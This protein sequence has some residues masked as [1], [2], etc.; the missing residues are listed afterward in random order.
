MLFIHISSDDKDR[1]DRE[2]REDKDYKYYNINSII[3]I[4][5]KEDNV[6]IIYID[7]SKEDTYDNYII[8]LK[9]IYDN[10][11]KCE[12]I[13]FKSKKFL[14][15]ESQCLNIVNITSSTAEN[16]QF[17]A[18]TGKKGNFIYRV[19]RHDKEDTYVSVMFSKF[20]KITIVSDLIR[21]FTDRINNCGEGKFIQ[22]SGTCGINSIINGL[23]LT[24]ST[25][26]VIF[27]RMKERLIENPEL[28]TQVTSDINSCPLED[29]I[30][31][32]TY[33]FKLF[34]QTYM[35]FDIMPMEIDVMGRLATYLK[36]PTTQTSMHLIFTL[37]KLLLIL[38]FDFTIMTRYM[39]EIVFLRDDLGDILSLK[40]LEEIF[41]FKD[42][43]IKKKFI[44]IF[45]PKSIKKVL[46]SP[47]QS[48]ILS[49]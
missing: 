16:M 34:Y 15:D 48:T 22:T 23:F 21:Y 2:D 35:N 37:R 33:I 31:L 32:E 3:N 10:C 26:N 24:K 19:R 49:L 9:I 20:S 1:E 47:T 41:E 17:L 25:R 40:G 6:V 45:D 29:G 42:I 43:F 30:A 7:I 12:M 44:I 27:R 28:V 5:D 39:R 4:T 38:E 18:S 11:E 13:L 46:L 8:S 14:V 36:V